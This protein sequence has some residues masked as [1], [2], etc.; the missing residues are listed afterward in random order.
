M[1]KENSYDVIMFNDVIEHLTKQEV[2]DILCLMKKALKKG[3]KLIIKVVNSANP[4]T[5]STSRYF[6]FTHEL[7][8]TE[9]SL[10][11]VLNAAGFEK[12]CIK[13]ADIYVEYLPFSFMLKI[14]SRMV[15]L[16]WFSL[17]GLYGR[18]SIKI[19]DKNLIAIAKK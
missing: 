16:V 2:L 10:Q 1:N 9:T 19:F 4:I 5:G 13:G 15:N 6:D 11:Q 17:N 7:G 18:T 14:L 3:G 8:F 12:V